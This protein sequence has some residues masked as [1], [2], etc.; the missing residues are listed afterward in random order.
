MWARSVEPAAEAKDLSKQPFSSVGDG[1]VQ[2]KGR[3]ALPKRAG[4]RPNS[5]ASIARSWSS[6]RSSEK[7]ARLHQLFRKEPPQA[8]AESSEKI[9]PEIFD[10][11]PPGVQPF[12]L[13]RV[14]QFLAGLAPLP[15]GAT[16]S[17]AQT[18]PNPELAKRT[19]SNLAT[20]SSSFVASAS[21]FSAVNVVHRARC[22][23]ASSTDTHAFDRL[24]ANKIA[25]R[26]IRS[27]VLTS[28]AA[29]RAG[30]SRFPVSRKV[31]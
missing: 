19:R 27:S 2:A 12:G 31:P 13:R 9:V 25:L 22:A 6:P 21:R 18:L 17:F 7:R 26:V 1:A 30:A 5:A 3:S 20:V 15:I 14:A 24:L 28:T 8:G 10:A 11:P 16:H 29:L 23:A 4:R